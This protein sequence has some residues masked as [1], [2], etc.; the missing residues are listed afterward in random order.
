MEKHRGSGVGMD[1]WI[2]SVPETPANSLSYG[3]AFIC[4]FQFSYSLYVLC[5]W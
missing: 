5:S 4:V 2:I 1:G 3:S